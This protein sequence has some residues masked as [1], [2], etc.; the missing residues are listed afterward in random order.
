MPRFAARSPNLKIRESCCR[1]DFAA[2]IWN[3]TTPFSATSKERELTR[4]RLSSVA[5]FSS[6]S[7]RFNAAPQP[8]ETLVSAYRNKQFLRRQG[9]LLRSRCPKAVAYSFYRLRL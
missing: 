9:N 8:Q 2:G 5:P 6:A 4:Q 1:P 7:R 3:W